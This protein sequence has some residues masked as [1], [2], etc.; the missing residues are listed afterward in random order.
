MNRHLILLLACLIGVL[1]PTDAAGQTLLVRASKIYTLAG[2]PLAPGQMLIREGKIVDVGTNLEA[3]KEAEIIDLK[4]GVILPGLVN[5]VSRAGVR[6]SASEQTQEVAP[7]FRVAATLDSR[8][9]EFKRALADGVTT[10]LL[11]PDTEGV[12]TGMGCVYRSAGATKR[13]RLLR[14]EVGLFVTTTT[15]PGEGNSA[16]ARPDTIYNRIPTNRM[17]VVWLLRQQ[18]GLARLNQ[19]AAELEPLRQALSGSRPVFGVAR[20]EFEI[21]ALLRVANEVGIQKLVLV[22]GYESY[23]VAAELAKRKVPVLLGSQSTLPTANAESEKAFWNQAL[24]LHQAG[25]PFAFTGQQLLDQARWSHRNGLPAEA[26]LAAITRSP[27][28]II[29]VSEEVGTL[30]AGKDADFVVLSGEPLL[31]TTEIRTVYIQ[32][33]SQF[34][35]D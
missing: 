6:G 24:V 31:W 30:A 33:K 10:Q 25:V 5:G 4:N 1:P 32:G 21:D 13:Q 20:A 11:C 15:D 7:R 3:P 18:F 16:R 26:A 12:I 19:E 23:R 9:P 28:A 35:Q 2:P 14:D 29:G 27:A 22:D 34:Q 8:A 17:G